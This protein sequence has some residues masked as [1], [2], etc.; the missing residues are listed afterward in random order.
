MEIYFRNILK[1]VLLL[2]SVIYVTF[3]TCSNQNVIYHYHVLFYI[4]FYKDSTSSVFE[5]LQEK[6]EALRGYCAGHR[7]RM[8][9]TMV[10]LWLQ[11]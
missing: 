1:I 3:F 2:N 8:W 11:G 9:T 7:A 10:P 6:A 4:F 5:W